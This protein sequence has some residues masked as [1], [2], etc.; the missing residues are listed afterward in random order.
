MR[1]SN[2]EGASMASIYRTR[3][4][5]YEDTRKWPRPNSRCGVLRRFKKMAA[6]RSPSPTSLTVIKPDVLPTMRRSIVPRQT[7]IKPPL[8]QKKVRF[9]RAVAPGDVPRDAGHDDNGRLGAA[10]RREEGGLALW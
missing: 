6:S 10:R 2:A 8:Q 5:G 9:S 4:P 3:R 7:Y 1:M